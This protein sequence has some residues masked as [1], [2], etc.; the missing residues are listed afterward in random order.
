MKVLYF[1]W[2]RE[3]I[4]EQGEQLDL[5]TGNVGD[6]ID[7][8]AERSPA[9]ELALADRDVLRFALDQVMVDLD[10]PIE[11]ATELAIFPPMTGG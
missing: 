11:D 7:A 5:I 8:L 2:V 6:A 1:A 10:H 9:H 4:G 3:R